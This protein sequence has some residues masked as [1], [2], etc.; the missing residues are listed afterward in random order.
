MSGYKTKIPRLHERFVQDLR[1]GNLPKAIET[2]VQMEMQEPSVSALLKDFEQAVT[3]GNKEVART[4]IV[5]IQ[6]AYEN[7]SQTEQEEI[8]KA[9]VAVENADLS[10]DERE[11]LLRLVRDSSQLSLQRSKFYDQAVLYLEAKDTST[12]EKTAQ[13]ASQTR[14]QEDSFEQTRSDSPNPNTESVPPRPTFLDTTTPSRVSQGTNFELVFRVSNVGG[15]T[16]SGV[17]AEIT[18]SAGATPGQQSVSFGEIP[19]GN[20]QKKSVE[21]GSPTPEEA[22]ISADLRYNGEV[23]DS[24]SQ[25]ITVIDRN[26]TVR[27]AITGNQENTL[28]TAEIQRAISHWSADE[29]VDGTGGELVTTEQIQAFI[30]EWVEQEGDNA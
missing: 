13:T 22:S 6:D 24:E 2:S 29:P 16:A 17:S 15:A 28:N 10:A 27:E 1:S 14:Q 26:L 11:A 3:D 23:V 20:T 21:I 7:R 18:E 5:Q 9:S 19:P 4:L 12:A 30:T 25:S 8:A